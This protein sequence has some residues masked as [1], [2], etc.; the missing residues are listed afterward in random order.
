M[1][2]LK[3]SSKLI[4]KILYSSSPQSISGSIFILLISIASY[5]CGQ[6]ATVPA[7]KLLFRP[8]SYCSGQQ[9]LSK[10]N[11]DFFVLTTCLTESLKSFVPLS[12]EVKN[13][14]GTAKFV[15]SNLTRNF[16]FFNLEIFFSKKCRHFQCSCFYFFELH[17]IFNFTR[18]DLVYFAVFRLKT[19]FRLIDFGIYFNGL[20]T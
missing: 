19:I 3:P 9:A 14:P 11:I 2:R 7:S 6:Q 4:L 5:C 13:M 10:R 16:F 20:V 1:N 15:G 18:L 12:L 17:L 8:A